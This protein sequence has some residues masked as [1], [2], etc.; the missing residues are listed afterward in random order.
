MVVP[1]DVFG[2]GDLDIPNRLPIQSNPGHPLGAGFPGDGT[3]RQR[4]RR[5]NPR[6]CSTSDSGCSN[7]AK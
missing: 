6:T 4:K 3:D 1:V 5:K 7:A 2:P